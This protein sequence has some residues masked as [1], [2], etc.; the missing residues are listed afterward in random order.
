MNHTWHHSLDNL[1]RLEPCRMCGQ[2]M[3]VPHS[4]LCTVCDALL[5]DLVPAD[6]A[7]LVAC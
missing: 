7:A 4:P 5:A 2:R 1:H 3:A 6:A